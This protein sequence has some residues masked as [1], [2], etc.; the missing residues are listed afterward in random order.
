MRF[1]YWTLPCWVRNKIRSLKT[2]V[3]DWILP[4]L[5]AGPRTLLWAGVTFTGMR[6]FGALTGLLGGR[7]DLTV[8]GAAWAALG[9]VMLR[10]TLDL[11]VCCRAWADWLGPGL[12]RLFTWRLILG[13]MSWSSSSRDDKTAKDDNKTFYTKDFQASHSSILYT[14]TRY[15]NT[16][17]WT[18]HKKLLSYNL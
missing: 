1:C 14:I 4:V 10:L 8:A 2:R 17:S 11:N 7:E 13:D 12:P 3:V 6:A 15:L 5:A 18:F 16:Y 9:P